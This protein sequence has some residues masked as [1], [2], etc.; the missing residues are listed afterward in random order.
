MKRIYLC[1][2]FFVILGGC[3]NKRVSF[4][5]KAQGTY[6]SISYFASKNQNLQED[7]DSILD[8]YN[9]SVSTYDTASV[10]SRFNRN[11]PGLAQDG[12]FLDNLGK[13]LK[14]AEKTEGAFDPT[15]APLVDAWGFG[16][17]AIRNT[18]SS[19]LDS[20]K[21]I[22]GYQ[23]IEIK[24]NRA[25]KKDPRVQLNFNAIAQGY[26]VDLIAEYLESKNIQSYL[27]DIGGEVKTKGTKAGNQKWTVGVEKPASS[28]HAGRDVQVI[29]NVS[30][31]CVATS[32]NYRK[33][34]VKDGVKYSHTI[35][36]Q[37]GRPVKHNLLSATVITDD[38]AFA[39]AYATAFMVMGKNEAM[40]YVQNHPKENLELFLIYSDEEGNYKSQSTKGFKKFI[41]SEN[42]N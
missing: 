13:A 7:I 36:P 11:E 23:K 3:V 32:G 30:G 10:I 15:V 28:K 41:R 35:N 5:G 14:V 21:E 1:L 17:Q 9:R 20:L 24:D 2:L 37:T 27:V 6:Y 4:N 25:I 33:F 8:A 42:K 34:Y 31:K 18:D 39:D 38:C 19:N 29:L 16:Y 12:I 26:S 40:K 22:V